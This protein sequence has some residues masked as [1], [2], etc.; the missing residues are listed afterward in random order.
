MRAFA[1]LESRVLGVQPTAM[2]QHTRGPD[3][4]VQAVQVSSAVL[5][6]VFP[7]VNLG[8]AVRQ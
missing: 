7:G 8:P 3:S 2:A 1:N 4:W 6:S 5:G